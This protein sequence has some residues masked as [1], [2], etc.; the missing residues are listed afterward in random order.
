MV[1]RFGLFTIIVL[2]EVVVGVVK[3]IGEV[4]LDL[5]THGHGLPRAR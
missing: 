5:V 4:D 1:E 3:G 2:G